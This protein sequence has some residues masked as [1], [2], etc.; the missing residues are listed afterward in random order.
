MGEGH[1]G[2]APDLPPIKRVPVVLWV[3]SAQ[4]IG[5][6]GWKPKEGLSQGERGATLGG[7][8]LNWPSCLPQVSELRGLRAAS[9]MRG[10]VERSWE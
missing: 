3:G 9:G 4:R 6:E 8:A 7:R 2:G 10:L 5:G 1:S